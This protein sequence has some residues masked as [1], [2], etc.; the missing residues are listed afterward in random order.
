MSDFLLIIPARY[1]SK[2][3]PGK[4]LIDLKGIP[5]L[6]RTYNQCKKAVHQSKILVA[7]DHKTI[8]RLC[9]RNNIK[10][11]MTSKKCLTGT[12]R[13]AEVAKK[14]KKKFYINV[15]GDEPVCNPSDIKKIINYA[16]KYPN[17]VINGFTE[18]KDRNTFNSPHVPKVIFRDNGEL[19]YM[20]RA[21]IPSN[22]K[23]SFIKAWR[24][25]CIYS[26]P[27]KSL[28][29]FTI[30]RK[31]TPLEKIEDL[32]LNRFIEIGHKVKM[33]KLSNKSIAVD[34]KD[35]LKKVKKI[36]KR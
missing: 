12:D 7:T 30:L 22:K 32:E 11:I 19:I 2:R 4:P 14:I 34:T 5:M 21:P 8:F 16:K 29:E 35:D 3:L 36:I 13:I 27:Y 1:N 17:T 28:K 26:F 18:I 9:K 31:K 33:I 20:S 23:K 24:Q 25:V 10:T 15:Q 6:I